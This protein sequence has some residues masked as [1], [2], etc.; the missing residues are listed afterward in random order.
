VLEPGVAVEDLA[1]LAPGGSYRGVLQRLTALDGDGAVVLVGH[2]PDLGKLAGVLLFGA[3]ASTL[4]LKKA[5]ACI[6]DFDGPPRAG[7]G[8]LML[9]LPPRVLRRLGRAKSRA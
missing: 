8:E 5:G 9:F 3:P 1:A 4:P 7:E 2:E 6:I